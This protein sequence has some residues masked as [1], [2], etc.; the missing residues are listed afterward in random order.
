MDIV[1]WAPYFTPMRH[2]A[3]TLLA[4]MIL[5]FAAGTVTWAAR[6]VVMDMA[7][8][9]MS[10]TMSMPG[11]DACDDEGS[12]RPADGM[13]SCS[14]TCIAPAFAPL[15]QHEASAPAALRASPVGSGTP[16]LAG[17]TGAPD[18]H[19]PRTIVLS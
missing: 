4:A 11:C 14:V 9:G 10:S 1:E 2:V 6:G 18:L 5:A 3:R 16:V 12:D 13:A 8:A 7:L 15:P 17:R 19:P